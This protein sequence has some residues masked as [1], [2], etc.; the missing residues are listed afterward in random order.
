MSNCCTVFNNTR[1]GGLLNTDIY[2]RDVFYF[3]IFLFFI[4]ACWKNEAN[5]ECMFAV[6]CIDFRFRMFL[7]INTYF[8]LNFSDEYEFPRQQL[9]ATI[10]ENKNL[11]V[12]YSFSSYTEERSAANSNRM[13]YAWK[14]TSRL[15][16]CLENVDS[17]TAVLVSSVAPVADCFI[18]CVIVF[19]MQL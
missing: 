12:L 11:G 17:L 3:A 8:R 16:I 14:N 13:K 9:L 6:T 2:F 18:V 4:T 10:G 7:E 5:E 19:A 1:K 15:V